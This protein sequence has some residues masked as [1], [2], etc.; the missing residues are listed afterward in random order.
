VVAE[1]RGREHPE[2]VVVLGA[3]LDSWDLAQGAVDDGAGVVIAMETARLIARLPRAPRRTVRVVLFMNEEHGLD[4]AKAYAKAHAA[5]LP[6][7]VAAL[8]ADGGAGRPI[9]VGLRAG[10]GAASLL[11]PQLVPLSV[12]GIGPLAEGGEGGADIG[13]LAR[14]GVPIVSVRQDMTH[15]FDWHHSAADTLDKVV[16]HELAESTAAFAWVAWS[17]AELPAALFRPPP[18]PARAED[19]AKAPAR[20]PAAASSRPAEPAK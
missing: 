5:E 9:E 15:Y 6:R 18:S 7:H 20:A 3:H 11:G 8:E 17:L 4:G 13:P 14:A 12:L 1:I 10:D 16:P 19:A 2:E